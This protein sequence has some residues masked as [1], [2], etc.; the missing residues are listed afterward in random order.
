M[1]Q[2]ISTEHWRGFFDDFSRKYQGWHTSIEIEGS[3]RL[4]IHDMPLVG[5]TADQKDAED[6]ISI[7]LGDR[8]DDHETH[9]IPGARMVRLDEE[10]RS[11][12]ALTIESES[13]ETA[14][15]RFSA[16]GPLHMEGI[17]KP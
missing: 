14:H 12:A 11:T 13:G 5:I 17:D 3:D 15:V 8:P 4:P 6:L 1:A 2:E 7:I 10:D 16:P 9:N